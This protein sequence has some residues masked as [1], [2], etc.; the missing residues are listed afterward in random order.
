MRYL[1]KAKSHNHSLVRQAIAAAVGCILALVGMK[2]PDHYRQSPFLVFAVGWA[3]VNL[4]YLLKYW[5]DGFRGLD[6]WP[7]PHGRYYRKW[8]AMHDETA[9][10]YAWL[11]E[12]L[13][14]REPWA[15]WAG[16]PTRDHRSR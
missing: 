14:N 6:Q 2:V 15:T 9:D 12:E 7:Q 10:Y 1:P 13:G 5:I 11:V 3:I 4:G 8:L 16:H